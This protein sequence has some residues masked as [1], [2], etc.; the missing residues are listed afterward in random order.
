MKN[1]L[2]VGNESYTVL[3]ILFK[4]IKSKYGLIIEHFSTYSMQNIWT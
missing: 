1:A 3:N 2:L 4:S